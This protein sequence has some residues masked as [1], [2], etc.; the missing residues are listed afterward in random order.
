MLF[1]R[2][3]VPLTTFLRVSLLN[4]KTSVARLEEKYKHRYIFTPVLLNTVK[5]FKNSHSKKHQKLVFK[6]N[7]CLMQVKS[8]AECSKDSAI[9]STFIK[10]PFVIKIF[11]LSSFEWPLKTGF[12]VYQYV[13]PSLV[14][15]HSVTRFY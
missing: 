3:L 9:L 11:I 13:T 15:I 10:L 5:P 12:T 8:I 4:I 2:L 1:P 7:Y 6:T 14:F